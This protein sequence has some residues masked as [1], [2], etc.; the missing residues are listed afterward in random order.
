MTDETFS[1]TWPR[2]S[3]ENNSASLEHRR[4]EWRAVLTSEVIVCLCRCNIID[5][6]V[7]LM[8]CVVNAYP[9]SQSHIYICIYI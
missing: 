1:I 9:L 7:M 4:V 2:D 3:I 5:S 8:L 6:F